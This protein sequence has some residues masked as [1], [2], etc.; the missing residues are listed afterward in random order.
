MPRI[1]MENNRLV[2]F[3]ENDARLSSGILPISLVSEAGFTLDSISGKFTLND[4]KS[5]ETAL[6]YAV[7]LL[8][9]EEIQYTLDHKAAQINEKTKSQLAN[10]RK[11]IALGTQIKRSEKTPK[12]KPPGFMKS[13]LKDQERAVSLHIQ[14]PFSADFSVPGSGKTWIAYATYS[15]LKSR[16]E[17]RKLFVVGPISSFQPWQDEHVQIFGHKGS[18]AQ[19]RGS[20]KERAWIYRN[21]Q[22]FEIFLISYHSFANDKDHIA[23][24]L[25]SAD[26][27]V[28]LDES[29]NVKHPD[30]KRTNTAL[31]IAP[32]CK[33]R[34]ILSGTPIPRAVDD[35][36][37][38]ISFLDP[39]QDLLGDL[40]KFGEI[41]AEDESL[42][43]IKSRIAPFYY[44]IRKRDF[45]PTLADPIFEKEYLDMTTGK[46]R[47][48]KGRVIATVPPAPIQNSIYYGIEGR[49]FRDIE[50]EKEMTWTE[51]MQLQKWQK[52]RLIR[53]L[54]VASNPGLLMSEDLDL[55]LPRISSVDL[56]IYR[57]IEQYSKLNETPVKIRRTID[58][59]TQLV[60]ESDKKKVIIWT[61]FVQNINELRR[62]LSKLNPVIVHGGIPKNEEENRYFH[63]I[64]E[65]RKFKD[66]KDC[67]VLIANPASLAESVSLHKNEKGEPVCDTAIYLDRTFNGAH[68]MQSLD[69]IHRVGLP[70]RKK[71]RYVLLH[72]HDTIDLDVDASLDFKMASMQRFLND[73]IER[74]TLE[75]D[76]DDITGGMTEKEDYERVTNRIKKH[77]E[78]HRFD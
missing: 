14:M 21:F 36:Y 6:A 37:S 73:D 20:A 7:N 29:H 68:Y 25:A 66:D 30:A 67:R 15:I 69:R 46:V 48:G 9:G 44:R 42:Q 22:R 26:F 70:P 1:A 45:V 55:G 41:I 39:N 13:L 59:V 49:I 11:A 63:R 74:F 27:M 62:R 18:F 24:M 34:M 3:I 76:Y 51:L 35:L 77:A 61:S 60:E 40:S 50:R 28:V 54:E 64:S 78:Q 56:P 38:Q 52:G 5:V 57:K 58:L 65:I 31:E 53:L 72:T 71:V 33:R 43:T 17:V 16:G 2:L 4:G 12:L 23:N 19:I 75:T 32:L 10:F 47:N 8:E